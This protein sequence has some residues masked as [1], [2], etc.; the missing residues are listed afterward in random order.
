MTIGIMSEA[1]CP[2]IADPGQVLVGVAQGMGAV[3]KPFAGPS[4]ILM[5]LMA[6]GMN[7]QQFRFNGYLPIDSGERMKSLK[8]LEQESSRK[9]CTEIFIETPYRNN[10]MLETIL[11]SCQPSTRLCIAVDI[12]SGQEFIKTKTIAEWKKNIPDL[13]KRPVV[14]CLLGG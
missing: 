8:E 14:F 7:G 4:A 13:H 5:A 12:T 2:G 6:S 10:Q 1:G 3:V 9:S 11:K